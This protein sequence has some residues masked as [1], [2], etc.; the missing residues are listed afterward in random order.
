VAA[1]LIETLIPLARE[2]PILASELRHLLAATELEID[3]DLQI[4]PE[5]ELLFPW[6]GVPAPG[7]PL[8]AHRSRVEALAVAWRLDDP[9]T[10]ASRVASLCREGE[11]FGRGW[12]R[13]D[14]LLAESLSSR[15]ETPDRWL[16]V[17]LDSEAD[18]PFVEPF[19]RRVVARGSAASEELW[20]RALELPETQPVAVGLALEV[21]VPPANVVERALVL[22]PQHPR[23]I[24]SQCLH[25]RVDVARLI[26]LLQHEDQAV[27]LSAAIGEWWRGGRIG[28]VREAAIEDWR[29]AIVEASRDLSQHDQYRL[30]EI[31]STDPELAEQWLLR[32]LEDNVYFFAAQGSYTPEEAA[33]SALGREARLRVL[34]RLTS[35]H[36]GIVA[37][38]VADDPELFRE[39]L[40]RPDLRGLHLWALPSEIDERWKTLARLALQEGYRAEDV[41]ESWPMSDSWVGSGV[42]HWETRREAFR[43]LQQDSE[44]RAVGIAGEAKA[45]RRIEEAKRNERAIELD[46]LA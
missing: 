46:G 29:R 17:L 24:E 12:H 6:D 36:Y 45:M 33:I 41:A 40:R 3:C 31:L 23:I 22:A 38:L 25:G 37:S 28:E 11:R 35:R 14:V 39:L 19:L 30:A 20:R 15:V 1:R 9:A 18:G 32:R 43:A 8:E 10:V 2:S 13:F 7:D 42:E 44:L 27:A 21:A 16:E 34:A 4:D 26:R 5:Y